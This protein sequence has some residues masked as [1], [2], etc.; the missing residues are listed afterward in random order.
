MTQPNA[1]NED[2]LFSTAENKIIGRLMLVTFLAIALQVVLL[3]ALGWWA[4]SIVAVAGT[5]PV[6]IKLHRRKRIAVVALALLAAV[7]GP[8]YQYMVAHFIS[9]AFTVLHQA[10]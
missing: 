1:I 3:P 2:L 9:V 6:V 4:A 5:M 8:L 7:S 10:I